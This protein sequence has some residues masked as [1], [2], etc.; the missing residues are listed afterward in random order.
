MLTKLSCLSLAVTS[1]ILS[2]S[3]IAEEQ[4]HTNQ[5]SSPGIEHIEVT[6][7]QFND[8]KVGTASGAMRG[9]ISILDT[10]QSVTVI[11]DFIT[12]EQLATNLSEVLVND[13]SVTGGSE[14]WNR[15]VF[16]LRGFELSS[17]SGFLIN[18]QQQ[19]S[20]YVQPIETLQQVEVLKGPSSM[21]YGQ[22]GPGGLINMVTKKSTYDSMI[23][24]GFDID[25]HGST[26]LQLDAGGSLNEAQTLRY[27][28]VLVKQDTQYWREYRDDSNQERDRWLGYLNVEFDVTDD[29]LLSVKYDHTQDKTGIDRGGWLDAD[30]ELI[31]GRDTIWDMPWAFTDNTI[32]NLG[33]ELTYHLTDDWKIK[34]GYN[35]QQFNR[36]R[37]DSSPSLCT[38]CGDD[39]LTDG[40][41][42]SP[43]DRYDDWQHKTG[44]VDLTGNFQTG[45]LGHQ[46]LIGANMLDYYYGQL[47]ESGDKYQVVMPGLPMP[48]PQ[49]DYRNDDTKSESEYKHYGFYI[50]DLITINDSWKA[51]A[52]MRYDEQKKEGAGNNSYAV[53]PKFGLIYSPVESAS[54]YLNYSKSFT[55]QGMVNDINDL[56]DQ[57]NLDPEYGEQY[58]LGAKW[59]LFDGSL[60]L[61]GAVF[62]ITVNNVTV[63]EQIENSE[64]TITTQSGEQRHRGFEI[65]SQGQISDKW[66]MTG[67]MMYLDAEYIR[68]DQDSLNGKT[69]VDA[70][71]L[72]ANI[73]T[74]Y[75]MTQ[76][77][78]FNFGAI[79]VGERF[80]NTSNAIVKDDYVRFDLGAAYSM[81]VMGSDIS[82]RM[83]IKNLFDTDYLDGG[84]ET[85][86]TVGEGRN[87]SLAFEAK[88]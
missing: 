13:S 53:S 58:E 54:I 38:A 60:L 34:A 22:S 23:D 66:F 4:S 74:R 29:L 12:D 49:L 18:G 47:K 9:D 51:L 24:I 62:D 1:A 67:S 72:S 81:P 83:N 15:Q 55:P 7:R 43:F 26:R 2:M 75:E 45:N 10:P 27:R 42:I 63:K 48:N 20:H 71:E 57:M 61:T 87:F 65:G 6:G 14:K 50:Q 36:Q 28:T 33:A 68:P 70:P 39:P 84:S 64:Q 46:L 76:D 37:L 31:G 85:D 44:F 82:V 11:P 88:F 17:G 8:Y 25:E 40:Y 69:P 56:N 79:Y 16:N 80:A 73:W 78:A 86:V 77:L 52:G 3:V 35:D 21:L 41:Y 30:G 59:E 19:W 5:A 32:S